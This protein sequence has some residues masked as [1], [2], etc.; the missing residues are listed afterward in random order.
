[1]EVYLVFEHTVEH[2]DSDLS[3][4]EDVYYDDYYLPVGKAKLS[5]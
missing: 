5:D 4:D 3:Y 2:F 1:M